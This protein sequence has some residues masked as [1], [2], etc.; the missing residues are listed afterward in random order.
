MLGWCGGDQNDMVCTWSDTRGV[1]PD[2]W[3]ETWSWDWLT[4]LLVKVNYGNSLCH[5]PRVSIGWKWV[6]LN[7]D[8]YLQT[9]CGKTLWTINMSGSPSSGV[10]SARKHRNHGLFAKQCWSWTTL[11]NVANLHNLVT[12]LTRLQNWGCLE[13]VL[14]G[15]GSGYCHETEEMK[16]FSLTMKQ[17]SLSNMQL[18]RAWSGNLGSNVLHNSSKLSAF[19]HFDHV[20]FP[21]LL[22][23]DR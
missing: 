9:F 22:S 16:L 13:W 3:V 6:W 20:C 23:I 2:T 18:M 11:E 7:E 8:N 5:L 4:Q 12:L 15:D 1:R 19:K 14:L 10:R 17:L 21:H